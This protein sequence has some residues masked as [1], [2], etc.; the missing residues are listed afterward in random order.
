MLGPDSRLFCRVDNTPDSEKEQQRLLTL[1][2][3]A[4]LEAES[5][6]VFEEATQTAAHFLDAPICVLGLVD[7]DRQWFKAAVGLSRIGLMND[8]ASSRQLPRHESFCTHVVDSHQVLAIDDAVVHPAFADSLLVQRYGIRAYLGVP[9][10]ASNGHCIGTLA[11]MELKPRHFSDRDIEFLE[12]TAR[13]SM[14]EFERNHLIK[15][16][17]SPQL[18]HYNPAST[19]TVYGTESNSNALVVNSTKVDLISQMTQELR[20]P[21]TSIL[22]MASVLSREIYGPLTDKQ[23]EYMDIV[24]NSG[25]YLLSL[26]NEILELGL[27]DDSNRHLNLSPVDVEM[28]CQ[29]ALSAVGQAA[30]RREQQIRLTVEPGPR[31]WLLDKDKV[32]QLLYHLVF[33]VIQSASTDSIIRVHVS[34][35]RQQ[36]NITLW[37]SHPWLGDG[38]PQTALCS[39]HLLTSMPPSHADTAEVGH[40]W[41]DESDSDASEAVS[42]L[43]QAVAAEVAEASLEENSESSRQCLGLM[44]SRQLA[45]MHSGR[46]TI[47][48]SIESGYRYVITLPQMTG[49]GDD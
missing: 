1:T 9:L 42:G 13:W 14:S 29:Q 41:F 31:I 5:V 33:S 18:H 49:N 25:Q 30:Q 22:G 27:L 45:E 11:I 2:T 19:P 7:R 47:Q 23:K 10:I 40:R 35:R 24:C 37:P 20:T 48:G 17:L 6:P 44:L 43:S 32:R 38:L 26:V 12:L 39:S 46:I 4:L 36:L 15:Q 16:Q 28:L 8:L 34:R 3:L 21:L